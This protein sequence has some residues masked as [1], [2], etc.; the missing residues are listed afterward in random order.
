MQRPALLVA[1]IF[2]AGSASAADLAPGLEA[3]ARDLIAQAGAG[4]EAY[5][6]VESLTLEV[7]P[8]Q[9]GSPAEARARDWAVDKLKSLGFHNVRIESFEMPRWLRGEERAEI[10]TPFPQPLTITTLGGSVGTPSAG[11]EAEVVRFTSLAAL[12]RAAPQQ[13]EGRIVFIDEPMT[14]TQDGSGYGVA[15]AK[16]W[17]SAYVAGELG[18]SAVL[19]RSVGTSSDRFAHTGQLGAPP[20]EGAS[21]VPAAALA[22]PDADQLARALL[23]G[24]AVTIKLLLTPVTVP[25]AVSGNVVAE[26]PGREQP[27]EIVLAAAHLDSWDLGTGA[28]DDGAGVAITVAAA[29][30]I[31][32]ILPR[33]PRRTIRI[34]LF[35]AEE[36]GVVGARA[37]AEHHADELDRHI[38]A[39]ESDFGA[40]DI[41]R[42]DSLVA[43]DTL[44][45]VAAIGEVLQGLGIG[46][47]HNIA[48]G[49]PDLVFLREAGVPVVDLKQNGW[50]YFDLHHTANDTLDKIA[51]Q[52]LDQNVAAYAAFLYL[53]AD[54]EIVFR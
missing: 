37:Y 49:G 51:P 30:L 24:R 13:V 18:A 1:A 40:G 50:D 12:Q 10:V 8:R 44:G 9:A 28:V 38:V 45:H 33:P 36:V 15:G 16:R 52:A 41:W 54:S 2:L 46:P 29:E 27:G 34:V 39:V 4:N 14:R 48:R 23:G 32:R 7:G 17:Q 43:E 31:D 26:L 25:G 47:G 53:V 5:A 21:G 11:I 3:A 35:G 19:I 6:I 22:A 42:L 20:R